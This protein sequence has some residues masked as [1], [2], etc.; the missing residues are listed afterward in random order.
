MNKVTTSKR[1]IVIKVYNTVHVVFF[2]L[3]DYPAPEI[4]VPTFRNTLSIPFS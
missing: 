1:K 2:L 4:Y 3:G